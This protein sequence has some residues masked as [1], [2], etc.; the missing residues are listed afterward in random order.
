MMNH[1]ASTYGPS[2]SA[3]CLL[4]Q[5]A[6]AYDEGHHLPNLHSACFWEVARK[7]GDFIDIR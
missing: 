2:T 3:D 5:F 6:I 4:E 7:T 1:I